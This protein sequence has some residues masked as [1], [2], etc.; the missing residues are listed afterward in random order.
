MNTDVSVFQCEQ[1]NVG[2]LGVDGSVEAVLH[3]KS[4][5]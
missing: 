4:V 2:F 1:V 3:I 5:P